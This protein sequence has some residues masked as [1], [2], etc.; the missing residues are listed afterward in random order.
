MLS[1]ERP[2]RAHPDSRVLRANPVTIIAVPTLADFFSSDAEL[3]GAV[4]FARKR[5]RDLAGDSDPALTVLDKALAEARITA[6]VAIK[7]PGA[8]VRNRTPCP[9]TV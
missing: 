4:E 7:G 2:S 3:R 5:I 9:L 8:S 6:Q 1:F